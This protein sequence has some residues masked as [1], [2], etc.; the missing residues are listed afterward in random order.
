VSQR[1]VTC[2]KPYKHWDKRIPSDLSEVYR[3][4]PAFFREISD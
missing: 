3:E 4:K 1:Q 2:V